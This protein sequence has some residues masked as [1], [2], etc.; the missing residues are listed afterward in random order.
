MW[1]I[2][3]NRHTYIY[4]SFFFCSIVLHNRQ[5]GNF[6]CH[7]CLIVLNMLKSFLFS[8][9]TELAMR[10]FVAVLSI[11][12]V[13]TNVMCTHVR[14]R[15]YSNNSACIH[16]IVITCTHTWNGTHNHHHIHIHIRNSAFTLAK[17]MQNI[18]FV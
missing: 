7:C 15:S 17:L 1:L 11:R 14:Q 18:R 16:T 12:N 6:L 5:L 2:S 4:F 8:A 3:V 13:N 10:N 9:P